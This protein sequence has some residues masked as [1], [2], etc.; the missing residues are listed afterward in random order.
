[1]QHGILGNFVH[2]SPGPLLL[3]VAGVSDVN[4]H[5]ESLDSHTEHDDIIL[6]EDKEIGEDR[7]LPSCPESRD[8]PTQSE[9]DNFPFN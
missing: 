1:M 9:T 3:A 8:K 4:C 5:P 7:P 6:E 2:L